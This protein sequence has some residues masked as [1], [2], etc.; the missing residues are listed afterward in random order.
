MLDQRP[1][2][3]GCSV[4]SPTH[5]CNDECH[6]TDAIGAAAQVNWE[7]ELSLGEKQRLA[8]ARLIYHHPKF[9]ILDECTSA[10]SNRMETR[11]FEI[12]Q[13][14]NITYI[15]ISHRPAL[16]AYHARVLSIG[17]P[18]QGWVMVVNPDFRPQTEA[19]ET[20][21]AQTPDK[22]PLVAARSALYGDF[23]HDRVP[24]SKGTVA[25]L[26]DL[27]RVGWPAG[28]SLKI[29]ASFFAVICRT[30]IGTCSRPPLRF[31]SYSF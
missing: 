4:L 22:D 14:L 7:E 31:H 3:A 16:S 15:T 17:K 27:L 6:S 20:A 11:I 13:E 29:G 2:Y 24:S 23:H 10:V 9:A 12:C 1:K 26:M 25:K 8:M 5:P 28:A 18:N 30:Y 19:L 21:S